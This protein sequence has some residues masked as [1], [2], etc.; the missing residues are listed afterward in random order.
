MIGKTCLVNIHVALSSRT[1]LEHDKREVI[2]Q[3]ARYHLLCRIR[4]SRYMLQ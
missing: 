4:R 2:D 1:S 3:L